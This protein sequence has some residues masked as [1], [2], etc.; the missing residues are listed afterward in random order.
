MTT[1]QPELLF[2]E[3]LQSH[4]AVIDSLDWPSVDNVWRDTFLP[5]SLMYRLQETGSRGAIAKRDF[6]VVTINCDSGVSL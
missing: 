4:G 5:H 1:S 2:I 6:A 3:W